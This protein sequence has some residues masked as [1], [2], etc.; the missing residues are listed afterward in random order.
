VLT[1]RN[2]PAGAAR[3]ESV[4]L[5][6]L[7]NE[8]LPFLSIINTVDVAKPDVDVEIAKR[9]DVPPFVPARE[10]LAN[11]EVVPMPIFPAINAPV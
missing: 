1:E 7:S 3:D 6:P 9:F 10:R 11:G 8:R 4:R 5:E 2:A